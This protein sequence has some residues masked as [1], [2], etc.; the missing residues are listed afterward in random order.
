MSRTDLLGPIRDLAE[1]LNEQHR[2]ASRREILGD[3][4]LYDLSRL[5]DSEMERL[6]AHLLA[7]TGEQP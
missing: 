2:F 5:S 6:H 1:K 3:I 4:D 7:A